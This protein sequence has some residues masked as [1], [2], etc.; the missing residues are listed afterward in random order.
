[1]PDLCS[2]WE[3]CQ[4]AATHEYGGKPFCDDHDVRTAEDAT[5]DRLR[6]EIERLHDITE[7]DAKAEGC[8]YWHPPMCA[9]DEIESAREQY[10]RIWDELNGKKHP[11]AANPWIWRIAFRRLDAPC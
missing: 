11:W 10:A 5:I 3:G 1:M 8:T 6:A 2:Y 4:S 9:A 7:D